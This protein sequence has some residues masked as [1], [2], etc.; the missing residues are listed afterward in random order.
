MVSLRELG[1]GGR[2]A[3]DVGDS[4]KIS[5]AAVDY[6]SQTRLDAIQSRIAAL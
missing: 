5:G 2:G 6:D 4:E 3:V 1:Q